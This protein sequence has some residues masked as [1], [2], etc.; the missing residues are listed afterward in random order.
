LV[1]VVVLMIRIV[2]G[3]GCSIENEMLREMIKIIHMY[4]CHQAIASGAGKK[5]RIPNMC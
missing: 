3:I 5:R 4:G 2:C 1:V